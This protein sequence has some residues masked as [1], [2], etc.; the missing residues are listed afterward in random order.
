MQGRR[1]YLEDFLR[2]EH[3]MAI[4]RGMLTLAAHARRSMLTRGATKLDARRT[5]E[6]LPAGFS[7]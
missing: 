5:V 4:G 3:C 7:E 1:G 2:G 6:L